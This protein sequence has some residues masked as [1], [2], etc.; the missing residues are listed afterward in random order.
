MFLIPLR[1]ERETVLQL[2]AIAGE[3]IPQGLL[4]E[5]PDALQKGNFSFFP[6]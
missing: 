1:E 3:A 5:G 6:L 4:L 2:K